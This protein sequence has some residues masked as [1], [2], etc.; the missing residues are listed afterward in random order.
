MIDLVAKVEAQDISV[1]T[2]VDGTVSVQCN[3]KNTGKWELK[4]N[5][6]A[7]IVYDGQSYEGV[8]LETS[9]VPNLAIG[10]TYRMLIEPTTQVQS[11]YVLFTI[12]TPSD[13]YLD[14]ATIYIYAV[15]PFYF[16]PYNPLF[17]IVFLLTN[18]G[19][20]LPF[21]HSKHHPILQEEYL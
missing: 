18:S 8:K 21:Y 1:A 10:A 9:A 20:S 15:Y 3:L 14:T 13:S 19:T 6:L 4:A 2:N 11:G 7:T 16:K 12:T 17:R 5:T